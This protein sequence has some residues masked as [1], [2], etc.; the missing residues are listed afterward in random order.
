[1]AAD[2]KEKPAGLMVDGVGGLA[3]RREPA[4]ALRMRGRIGGGDVKCSHPKGINDL[5][6]ITIY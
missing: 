3:R 6:T 5:L 2:V 4:S 1:M